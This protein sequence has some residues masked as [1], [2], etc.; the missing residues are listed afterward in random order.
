MWLQKSENVWNQVFAVRQVCE[1]FFGIYGAEN[2]SML[3]A[4]KTRLNVIEMRCLRSMF[5]GTSMD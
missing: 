5:G 3:V 2:W 4:E 1:K